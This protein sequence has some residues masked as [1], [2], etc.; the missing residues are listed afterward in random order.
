[1]AGPTRYYFLGPSNG[2]AVSALS[3]YAYRTLVPL[4]QALDD[5]ATA[6]LYANTASNLSEAINSQLWNADL[7]AYS[8]SL[9]APNNYSLT[10][11]A[12]TILSGTANS[13]QARS[14][15]TNVLPDLRVGVGYKTSSSDIASNATQLSPNTQGF[16]LEALFKAHRDLGVTDLTSAKFLL[17]NLW[18]SMVTRNEYYSGASWEY[19]FPDGS[20]GLSLFTSLSHPWG[21]GAD[22]CPAG[23][24]P[25]YRTHVARFQDVG[26]RAALDRAR[27][28]GGR[29]DGRDAFWEH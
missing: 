2:S 24:R 28:D 22:V 29:W 26:V 4:A 15:I 14:M 9:D 27:L 16:L 5:G 11:M 1:M 7:G 10:A 20:P 25:G 3:A 8:L 23:V 21:R 13:S 6:E 12:F 19:L 18:A 17:D